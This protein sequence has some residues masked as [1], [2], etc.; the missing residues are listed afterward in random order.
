VLKKRAQGSVESQRLF[1]EV[2][3]ALPLDPI[4]I[5]LG[6][7]PTLAPIQFAGHQGGEMVIVV[8]S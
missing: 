3:R 4:S 2:K 5:A 6:L 7:E 8:G 1:R